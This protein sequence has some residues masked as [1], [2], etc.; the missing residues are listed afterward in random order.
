MKDQSRSNNIPVIIIT[1]SSRGLGR[2]IAVQL[3]SQ[4]YSI[5]INYAGNQAAAKETVKF[6]ERKKQK[7]N[8]VFIPIKADIGDKAAR[9]KLILATLDRFGRIDALVNN[10]G[11][12][13]SERADITKASEESFEKLIKINLQGPYFLTQRVVNHWLKKK[14]QSLLANG[15]KIIF[16]SSISAY[17]A[18]VNRGDYCLSKAGIAM[19]AKLWA[20]RLASKGI[21]VFELRPG[22]MKTDMTAGVSAKYDKL[23]TNGLVPQKRWGNGEDLGLAVKSLLLGNFPFSTGEVINVDGGFHLQTL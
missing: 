21:Q 6:C 11:I 13:P 8:Q 20:T 17:T 22:I 12:A 19:A 1:G 4:G 15:F 5:V 23:I 18:S 7:N 14:Y 9:E 10:A 2:G 3:A 16:I